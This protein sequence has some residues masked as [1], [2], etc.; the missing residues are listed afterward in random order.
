M[1]GVICEGGREEEER[2]EE[3]REGARATQSCNTELGWVGSD[4]GRGR[5]S[6][7]KIKLAVAYKMDGKTVNSF[8]ASLAD[9]GK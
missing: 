8:P 9:Y 5:E 3:G 7:G 4:V 1:R 6:G 2:R